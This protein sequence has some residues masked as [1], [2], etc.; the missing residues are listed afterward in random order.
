MAEAA[1]SALE[2][3]RARWAGGA[4]SASEGMALLREA[5]AVGQ[6][7]P[8][9]ALLSAEQAF[10]ELITSRLEELEDFSALVDLAE[11]D[12]VLFSEP[13]RPLE[14]WRGDFEEFLHGEEAWLVQVHD[15]PDLIEEELFELTQIAEA[16]G[17]DISEPTVA[18]EARIEELQN[19]KGRYDDDDDWRDWRSDDRGSS[20][21]AEIDALFYSLLQ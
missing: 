17:S 6:L 8:A 9:G 4:G 20:E 13:D 1:A 11:W 12:P 19:N 14:S 7:L 21:D 2:A 10:L 5:G 16:F 15:D 3:A 18:I